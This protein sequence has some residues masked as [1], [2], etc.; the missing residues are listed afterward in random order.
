MKDISE[1]TA[2]FVDHHGLYQSLARRL[3]GENGFK[4]VIYSDPSAEDCE[5][6]NEAVIGETFPPDD[7]FEAV[8]DLWL[9]KKEIDLYVVPD[10]KHM[11]LQLELSSQGKPVW[12]SHRSMR[13]E[14]SRELFL[15]ALADLGMEVPKFE[16]IIG[17]DALRQ[18]LEDKED[19]IIK[20]STYRGTMETKKWTSMDEDEAWLDMLAVKLGGVKRL[21]PFLVFESIDTPFEMGGDTYVVR[22]RT[23]RVALDG[24]EAKDNAYLAALKPMDQMPEQIRSVLEAFLPLLRGHANFWTMEVRVKGDHF[25]FID[26][27][28]RG[29][30]PGTASQCQLYRNLPEIIAAGAEG[31]IV[32]PEASGKFAAE[33][34]LT[35]KG[36]DVMW[37]STRVPKAL[38][39]KMFL[40]GFCDV[41]GRSW[42]PY[43]ATDDDMIGWLSATGDTPTETVQNILAYKELLPPGVDAQTDSLVDLLKEINQAEE[44]GMEF[45]EH[46]MPEPE[47]VVQSDEH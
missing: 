45:T 22:G 20:I 31:E 12:G 28:P 21:Q 24:Y 26:N 1:I 19:Q 35:K 8:N 29:P 42:F 47:I 33:V 18:Y 9:R 41:D 46:P 34:A 10:S 3:I 27:T 32:E 13:L 11:G 14:H 30:L 43:K 37:R 40:S 39:G 2:G 6:V 44:Q 36:W 38:E 4:R 7:R 23:P 15:K 17:T 5:T 25:Y 16:R